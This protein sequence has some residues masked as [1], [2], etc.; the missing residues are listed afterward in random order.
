M[1]E[2]PAALM[3]RAAARLLEASAAATPAPWRVAFLDG[4]V[5]VVDGP[6]PGIVA[7]PRRADAELIAILRNAAEA[8]AGWLEAEAERA[9][10]EIGAPFVRSP[11]L[12][13]RTCDGT[14][15]VP[16]GC[17]CRDGALSVARAVLGEA[18]GN[19]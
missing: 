12:R 8:L 17:E 15:D 7:D 2:H 6:G 19:G 16:G 18:D 10:R 3:R 14:P 5:P 4:R 11:E 9:S 13:C 1:A